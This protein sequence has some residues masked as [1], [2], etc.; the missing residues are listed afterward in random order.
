MQPKY[1]SRKGATGGANTS[2]TTA[3][4]PESAAAAAVEAVT[5]T[6]IEAGRAIAAT[7]R[8][9]AVGVGQVAAR[10][11]SMKIDEEVEELKA[12]V[13]AAE[14]DL[15]AA[16][17]DYAAAKVALQEA[18]SDDDKRIASKNVGIAMKFVTSLTEALS[19]LRREKRAVMTAAVPRSWRA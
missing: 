14:K 16:K 17:E 2:T 8:E 12:K 13:K 15:A 4:K 9:E 5:A 11:E 19:E 3:T 1:Q 18:K 10:L 7:T 6:T